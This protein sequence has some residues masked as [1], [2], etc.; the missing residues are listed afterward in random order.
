MLATSAAF[1]HFLELADKKQPT[2]SVHTQNCQA[3][4]HITLS[5]ETSR[6]ALDDSTKMDFRVCSSEDFRLV[7]EKDSLRALPATPAPAPNS[8]LSFLSLDTQWFLS[9][10]Y[11]FC[12][13]YA[14][15]QDTWC[16]SV[17]VQ[18][19]SEE[20]GKVP[21]FVSNKH[22]KYNCQAL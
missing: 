9:D 20:T 3:C 13:S 19:N 4:T 14:C 22:S 16:S 5:Q 11:W 1:Q 12:V 8:S 2:V 15:S 17:P 21:V 6:H 10:C 18:G 7:C